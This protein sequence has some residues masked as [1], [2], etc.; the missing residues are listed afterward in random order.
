MF[1]LR[2]HITAIPRQTDV[3][4]AAKER[5]LYHESQQDLLRLLTRRTRGPAGSP[6]GFFVVVS[7][8]VGGD[9]INVRGGEGTVTVLEWG[10]RRG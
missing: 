7:Q 1:I 6:K 2:P 10:I 8:F 5:H 4:A 9:G 3:S